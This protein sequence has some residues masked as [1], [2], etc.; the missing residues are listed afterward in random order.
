M[1]HVGGAF[2]EYFEHYDAILSPAA[3]G[4]APAGLATT[5]DPVMQTVWTFAG[6]PALS[7]PLLQLSGGMPLGVQAV[8]A[9]HNDGRLLRASRWLVDEFIERSHA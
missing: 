5:G 7:M 6:L 4:A 2:D 3:L 8:G 1:A 9:L